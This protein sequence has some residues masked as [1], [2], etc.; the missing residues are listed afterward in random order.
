L[1]STKT[2]PQNHSFPSAVATALA[3]L[4]SGAGKIQAGQVQFLARG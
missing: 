3:T 1:V 2:F 4:L